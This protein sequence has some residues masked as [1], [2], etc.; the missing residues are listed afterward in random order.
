MLAMPA[1]LPAMLGMPPISG[2]PSISGLLDAAGASQTPACSSPQ[3]LL[4][5]PCLWASVAPVPMSEVAQ[6]A[7]IMLATADQIVQSAKAW[8]DEADRLRRQFVL[9]VMLDMPLNA[10]STSPAGLNP[11]VL[12]AYK[13][14]QEA[15]KQVSAAKKLRLAAGALLQS[16]AGESRDAATSP[17]RPTSV[18][19]A[20]SSPAPADSDQPSNQFN[21]PSKPD[22]FNA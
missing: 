8:T 2:L 12:L 19:A 15:D 11:M 10:R 21:T 20:T 22:T 13:L 1:G 18:Q 9:A 5:D 4:I 17:D 3:N 14:A 16:R 6:A 7:A